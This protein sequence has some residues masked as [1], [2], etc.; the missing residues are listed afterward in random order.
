MTIAERIRCFRKRLGIT[1]EE[2]AKRSE[3]HPVSIRR[4]ETGKMIPQYAQI[5]KLAKALGVSISSISG[6]IVIPLDL[7]NTSAVERQQY[8]EQLC[9]L[10]DQTLW[11]LWEKSEVRA[12]LQAFEKRLEPAYW[13]KDRDTIKCSNCGFGFYP[14]QP[15]F[16]DGVCVCAND[17][18]FRPDCCPKCGKRMS[19]SHTDSQSGAIPL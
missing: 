3:L 11:D 10:D 6:E 1:Q 12:K 2:L 14:N 15:W 19:L 13:E 9:D 7:T 8:F 18:H 17:P 4:Y 5:V 16:Q